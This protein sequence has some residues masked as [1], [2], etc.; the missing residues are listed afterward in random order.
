M[1]MQREQS[2]TLYTHPYI[3]TSCNGACP[4]ASAID[5]ASADRKVLITVTATPKAK[6]DLKTC[7]SIRWR[8]TRSS[9]CS[10]QVRRIDY[11]FVE[12]AFFGPRIE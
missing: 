5:A 11:L 4:P 8:A 6:L 10:C 7:V 3:H 1:G 2:V 12:N 9:L